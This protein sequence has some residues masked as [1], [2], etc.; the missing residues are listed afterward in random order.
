LITGNGGSLG[1]GGSITEITHGSS[2]T[3]EQQSI[4]TAAG[5]SGGTFTLSFL[6]PVT[7][8]LPYNAS[9]AQIQS[10][11]NALGTINT[12]T[13]SGSAGGPWTVTFSGGMAGTPEP[14]LVADG[15]LLTGATTSLVTLTTIQ[16]A[17]GPLFWS[18]PN[19]WLPFGVPNTGDAAF[20]PLGNGSAAYGLNQLS[21]FTAS[22]SSNLCTW[23]KASLIAGQVVTLTTTGTLPSGLSAG[24]NYYIVNVNVDARTFQLSTSLAGT[25]VTMSDSGMGTHTVGV[26]LNQL[27]CSAAWSGT[28]GLPTYNASGYLEYRQ[29]FLHIGMLASGTQQIWIGSGASG[30]GSSRIKLDTDVDRVDLLVEQTGSGNDGLPAIYFRGNNSG[31]TVQ[32]LGGELC[33]APL[34]GDVAALASVVIRGGQVLLGLGTNL[35]GPL[36]KT[37]GTLTIDQAAINGTVTVL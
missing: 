29:Q 34:P 6:G 3:N 27:E 16:M 18:D 32:V 19:N 23:A 30:S 24:T 13:V 37:S 26:R 9:A 8:A 12:C 31:N 5:T 11:L 17:L 2:G 21:T 10:A 14:L 20:F 33:T 7:P 15:S 1:G 35:I 4:T 22:A 28:I 36:T 25:P